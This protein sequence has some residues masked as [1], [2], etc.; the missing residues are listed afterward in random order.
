[1]TCICRV[2]RYQIE[3]YKQFSTVENVCNNNNTFS[4]R[5]LNI[6]HLYVSHT[7]MQ[8]FISDFFY[9]VISGNSNSTECM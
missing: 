2:D 3:I 6:I 7:F 8:R 1:M 5:A 9:D 4:F